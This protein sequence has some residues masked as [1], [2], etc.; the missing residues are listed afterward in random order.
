MTARDVTQVWVVE[1]STGEY[2][3]YQEWPVIAYSD[4]AMAREHAFQAERRAKELIANGDSCFEES[5]NEW[6]PNMRSI[7]FS[8]VSYSCYQLSVARSLAEARQVFRAQELEEQRVLDE[9]LAAQGI[10]V[11]RSDNDYEEG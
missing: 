10:T 1:G 4:E 9:R 6:D 8:G 7:G 11:Q 3:D 2:S 5:N